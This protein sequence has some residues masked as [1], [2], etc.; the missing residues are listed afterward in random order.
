MLETA[1]V[2]VAPAW[3]PDDTTMAW[4]VDLRAIPAHDWRKYI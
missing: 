3:K 4:D 2:F 1:N